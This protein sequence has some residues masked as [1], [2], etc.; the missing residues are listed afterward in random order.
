MHFGASRLFSLVEGYVPLTYTLKENNMSIELEATINETVTV[1]IPMHEL[2]DHVKDAVIEYLNGDELAKSMLKDVMGNAVEV[3]VRN[4]MKDDENFLFT[5]KHV[6]WNDVF[7]PE[8]RQAVNDLI[9]SDDQ[10]IDAMITDLRKDM[11]ILRIVYEDYSYYKAYCEKAGLEHDVLSRVRNK[12][13]EVA[14]DMLKRFDENA[15]KQ[16]LAS[17]ESLGG[18]DG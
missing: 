9:E 2:E 12:F 14:E 10:I 8:A 16:H 18:S 4:F 3:A 11:S 6:V 13:R 17:V 15:K 7:T 5:L 1:E